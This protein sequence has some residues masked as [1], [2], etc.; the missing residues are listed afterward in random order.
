MEFGAL[1]A[2]LLNRTVT[3]F[4]D[5]FLNGLFDFLSDVLFGGPTSGVL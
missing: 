5:L 4:L 1:L 3:F 2:A